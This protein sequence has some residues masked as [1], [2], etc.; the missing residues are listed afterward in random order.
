MKTIDALGLACPQPV[1][2]AKQALC[3]H[4]NEEVLVLVDNQTATENLDRLG[5]S[6]GRKAIV[7]A[8]SDTRFEVRF[9]AR[10]GHADA[11]G[12]AKP[13]METEAVAL[14]EAARQAPHMAY[15]VALSGEEM[16]SG[17]PAFGRQL[18]EGFV[19]AL[20]EQD[21]LPSHVLCYNRGV[22]LSTLNRKT[23]EDLKKLEARGVEILSCGLCLDYYGLKEHL[24]VG[25][26]TNM[27]R[28]CELM[29][30]HPLVRP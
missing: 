27:Y 19:Y 5:E 3:A 28:I 7:T 6:Q 26:V 29:T 2:L 23:V 18:L 16:G 14:P 30:T 8:I 22:A 24:Q 9:A 17:D 1:I 13:A 25:Q 11:P 20:S 10:K 21:R 15:V 4:P 12:A